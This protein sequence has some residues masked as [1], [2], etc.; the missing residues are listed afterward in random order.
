[1]KSECNVRNLTPVNEKHN[2]LLRQLVQNLATNPVYQEKFASLDIVPEDIKGVEDL[3]KLP[4][5]TKQD[6]RNHYPFGLQ[7]APEKDVVRVHSSSGTTGT[8]VMIPYTKKDVNVWAEMM[9]R[10]FKMVGIRESDRIQITPGYGLWT[11]GIGFQ[12]GAELLGAMAVPIGPG[13]T[14][15]QLKTM[16]DLKTTVLIG[17]SSYG[18]LLAEEAERKGLLDNLN[19]RLG[20]FGS[21]RWGQ[22]MRTRIQDL[23]HMDTFDI[24]G[25]TEIYGPGIA[26]DCP[27]HS[28]LHY[29]DDHLIFEI[30]DPDTGE[31]LPAG[32][33]GELVITTLTKEGLPLLR[34]RTRDITR[35]IPASCACG[36]PYPMIDRIVGRSDD[37]IK[38]K[39][40]QV[41]PA[42]IEILLSTIPELSSE[43]Q[44]E[45]DRQN[46]KEH[47]V[48]RV[49]RKAQSFT[50]S[51][52]ANR[53]QKEIKNQ[54]G[55][56]MEVELVEYK[57]LPRTE[58]KT[59]RV[60]D[61]RK[62][63]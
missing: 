9:A 19:L 60:L 17:T 45:I 26:I 50:D 54:I 3:P 61:K 42:E 46:G 30:I 22:R 41:Y 33:K 10:C 31:Q 1:M 51:E 59:K 40:V 18:L 58:K 24:Y 49:E 8:P 4:F 21:E 23:L 34:F 6:L 14:E 36:S 38:V 12:A 52:L 16:V 48:L 7:V 57:S 47:A 62:N 32:C 44:I 43:Y 13:N 53:C 11:A 56:T 37:M 55:L 25:L 2:Y 20:V 5:T 63:C 39:G 27:C 28:G 35:I 29:W 15:R